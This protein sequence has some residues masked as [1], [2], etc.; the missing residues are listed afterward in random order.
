MLFSQR[1]LD[2]PTSLGHLQHLQMYNKQHLQ[3]KHNYTNIMCT[4]WIDVHSNCDT[5]DGTNHV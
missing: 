1:D 3:W 5:H 4:N 2:Y